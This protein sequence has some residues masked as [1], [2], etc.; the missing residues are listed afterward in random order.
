MKKT[1][2]YIKAGESL[3]RILTGNPSEKDKQT[4]NSGWPEKEANKSDILRDFSDKDYLAHKLSLFAAIDIDTAWQNLLSRLALRQTRGAGRIRP[5]RIAIGIGSTAAA[6]IITFGVLFFMDE[7]SQPMLGEQAHTILSQFIPGKASA[8]LNIGVTPPTA[9]FNGIADGSYLV[10]LAVDAEN[11]RKVSDKYAATQSNAV[12]YNKLVVS[13]GSEFHFTLSDGSEVWMNAGSSITY[14]ANNNTRERNVFLEKGEAYFKVAPDPHRPF[15]VHCPG[16][17]I[18]ALGTEFNIT[19]YEDSPFIYTTLVEGSV[20]LSVSNDAEAIEILNRPGRQCMVNRNNHAVSL[21]D[22][23]PR[24]YTGWKE[25]FFVFD[26]A[27]MHN[28][29]KT[30]S[31]WYGFEFDITDPAL[32]NYHFSGEFSRFDNL[33]QVLEVIRVTGIPFTLGFENGKV[34]IQK[35]T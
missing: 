15:K 9:D 20:K 2:R 26:R 24:I 22:V 16:H 23:N 18:E 32:Y 28:V 8:S 31:R 33:E 7:V 12:Q 30:L 11:F 4:V 14:F 34:I 25:G 6:A 19:A 5:R 3:G 35:S 17:A 21:R 1:I 27:S 13:E 29:M 10:S